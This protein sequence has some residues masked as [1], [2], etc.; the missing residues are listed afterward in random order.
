[1]DDT[2]AFT[3]EAALDDEAPRDL[4]IASF[5][6]S[7]A[8]IWADVKK[9]SNQDFKLHQ[10]S[11]IED[12]AA[13]IKKQRAE[14]PAG[15]NELYAN[16]QGSQYMYSMF[17]TQNINLANDRYPGLTWTKSLDYIKSFVK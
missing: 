3:A 6:I 11:G 4:Q 9:A 15:G 5:Q 7:P 1:M 2:A 14:N 13:F 10:I 8:M 16:W 17:T 12:F